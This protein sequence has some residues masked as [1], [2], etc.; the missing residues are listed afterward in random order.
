[1]NLAEIEKPLSP[2][3]RF[4]VRLVLCYVAIFC[5]DLLGDVISFTFHLFSAP[6]WLQTPFSSLFWV[7][8]VPGVAKHVL[9][10]GTVKLSIWGSGDTLYD[11]V[12]MLCRA[13]LAFLGALVW[14]SVDH[15]R[16]RTVVLHAWLRVAVRGLLAA[17]MFAYGLDKVFPMQF[18]EMTV[19]RMLVPMAAKTPMGVLWDFMAASTG[20]TIF[21][22]LV[23]VLA[24]V[25]LLVPAWTTLGALIAMAAMTNI[26]ALNFFYDIPVKN[27]SS[28]LLLLTLVLLAPVMQRL[29]QFFLLNRDVPAEPRLVL[30]GSKQIRQ[31]MLWAP[32]VLCGVVVLAGCISAHQHFRKRDQ[33]RLTQSK[34]AGAWD[35][36]QFVVADTSKPLFT[37]TLTKDMKIPEWGTAWRRVVF[38]EHDSAEIELG[39]GSFD[40]VH[41][42]EENGTLILTDQGD[43]RWKCVLRT[44]RQGSDGL[45]MEGTVNGNGVQITLRPVDESQFLLT[46]RTFHWVNEW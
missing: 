39:D 37:D 20:Y 18:R 25:L 43:L 9:R 27:G 33:A 1:M 26:V 6:R 15:G 36:S 40:H 35:V 2:W 21:T 24:G 42:E 41:V 3:R 38:E 45:N 5:V 34:F 17:Q 10:L 46:K 31:T 16:R 23:E 8:L 13:V 32:V 28:H 19:E 14:T 12:Q 11:W 7:R 4:A 30:S 29:V 22:G 44:R